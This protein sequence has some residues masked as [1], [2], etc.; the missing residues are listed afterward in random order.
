V[1]PVV[2]PARPRTRHWGVLA[3]FLLLVLGP[4]A[5]S[6]WYLNARAVDQFA[7]T[8]GFS[9]RSEET[10][11]L[12][13]ILGG[14]G[15]IAGPN[16]TDAE[17]LYRF[18]LSQEM[19]ATVDARLD[20]RALYSRHRVR[21]P[22]FGLDPSGTIEDLTDYWPRMV[23]VAY[24]SATG[25]IEI[26]VRAFTAEE[27]RSVALAVFDESRRRINEISAIAREDATRYAR[28]EL[29]HA[30]ERLKSARE[31]VTAFRSRTLIVDPTADLQGQM[32]ILTSLQAQL[33]EALIQRDLL[34]DVT[35][36]SDPRVV[37]AETRIAVIRARIDA[38]RARFGPGGEG[39]GGE[40]YATL[41]AEYERL[42]VE[43]EFA[44]QAYV[45][46]LAAL[47]TALAQAQR[48]SRYLAP[49]ITPTLAERPRYP[50]RL[51]LVALATFFG[52]L[53]WAVATL[54]YYSIRDRR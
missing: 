5:I 43:R 32:S 11:S 47:D 44:E 33:A 27:A 14:L 18:I 41:V 31:A 52:F 54:I 50:D 19:V 3:S 17:V 34:R 29:A 40:D 10:Q 1:P 13:P 7:S 35:R 2:G 48:T 22:V 8:V 45:A 37:Q 49:H 30:L 38:E 39:P 25:L 4:L 9:V 51:I 20:L 53:V 36:E 46:A 24:D 28:D 12:G 6:A 42:A 16:T 26:E 23:R 21:D 15:Q